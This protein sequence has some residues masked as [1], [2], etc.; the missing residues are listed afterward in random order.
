[1]KI[2]RDGVN[3][4]QIKRTLITRDVN[5]SIKERA[6]IAVPYISYLYAFNTATAV[7]KSF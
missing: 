2:E 1:M 7:I 3:L 5:K 6:T 4:P